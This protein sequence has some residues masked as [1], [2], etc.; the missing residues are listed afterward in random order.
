[1]IE[2]IVYF[3][4]IYVIIGF[5]FGYFLTV[6]NKEENNEFNIRNTIITSTFLWPI[7]MYALMLG[8]IEG[9]KRGIN[10]HK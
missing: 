2:N 6:M 9:I 8:I 7:F 1:M 4:C 5:T 3:S 10:K